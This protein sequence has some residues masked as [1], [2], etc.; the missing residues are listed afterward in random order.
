MLSPEESFLVGTFILGLS[1]IT[2]KLICD[3]NDSLQVYYLNPPSSLR[4]M[5]LYP[6]A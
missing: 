4:R 5:K 3:H 2:T 1:F 6:A